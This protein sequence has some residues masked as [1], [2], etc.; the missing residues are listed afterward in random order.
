MRMMLTPKCDLCGE[1]IVVPEE[2][3]TVADLFPAM[4]G[5][6]FEDGTMIN[7]CRDCMDKLGESYGSSGK[8]I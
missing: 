5:F 3:Q 2:P 4:I 8:D 6:E 1:R 7:V